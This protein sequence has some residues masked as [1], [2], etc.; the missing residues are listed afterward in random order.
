M[1]S[2]PIDQHDYVNRLLEA[3]RTTP[4]TSGTVR[5][6]DRVLAA[7]DIFYIDIGPVFEK[8]EGDGGDT[9]VLGDD[10]DMH[11]AKRD[12]RKVFDLVQAKWRDAGLAG[13]ALY[14]FASDTAQS[15]GWQLYLEIAGHRLADFPHKAFHSGTLR[16]FEHAPL[17]DL[18]V[19]EIQIRHPRRPFG[20]FYEDLLLAR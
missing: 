9:F 6:P 4:G 12:V 2:R 14:D 13:R 15:L 8:W 5:R 11:A 17:S 1:D 3:Y 19:L 10:P 20:A 7:N 18:W 16:E